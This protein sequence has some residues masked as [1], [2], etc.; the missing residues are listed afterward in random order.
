MTE[1]ELLKKLKFW[2]QPTNAI[3]SHFT[4][5]VLGSKIKAGKHSRNTRRIFIDNGGDILFVAHIDTVLP[6]KLKKQTAK[7]IHATGL[8]DRLGCLFALNLGIELGADILLTDDEEKCCSTA[9]YHVCKNYN[10]VVEF[11]RAGGDVVTY[12]NQS[13][14]FNRVLI[15]YW[16]IGYGSYSD[17]SDLPT[18]ACCFN[19]GIGYQHAHSKDSYVDLK[20]LKTQIEKFRLFY[21]KY[22]DTKFV[23]DPE[24]VDTWKN[25]YNDQCDM[26]GGV[27]QVDTIHGYN[28][29]YSCFGS[30]IDKFLFDKDDVLNCYVE[31]D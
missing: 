30:A 17:I 20:V 22:K 27:D 28:I 29:C 9:E 25:A 4:D 23:A 21:D 6:P 12:D 2:M 24:Q 15:E 5:D 3:F 11:D 14:A 16:D 19:L 18:S 26:C 7:R 10:W 1:L 31:E 8:D 13:Y